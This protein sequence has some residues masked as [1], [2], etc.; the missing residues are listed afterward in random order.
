MEQTKKTADLKTYQKEYRAAHPK[1]KEETNQ[2]MKTYIKK[3]ENITCK[4]CL[5]HHKSY[6]AYKHNVTQKHL[7]ALIAI[8]EKEEAEAAKLQSCSHHSHAFSILHK[9][10]RLSATPSAW[11]YAASSRLDSSR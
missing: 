5:G 1:N 2:Y 4:I 11:Q 7:K 6:S 3:A 10:P 9:T 8:K